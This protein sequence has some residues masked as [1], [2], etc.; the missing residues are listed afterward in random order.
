MR[1][2]FCLE[3]LKLELA[4][5]RNSGLSVGFTCGAFD[6][7]HVGHLDYLEKARALCDRLIVAVNSDASIRSYKNPLRP[8]IAEEQRARLMA[9][10]SC[11]DAVIIMRETRPASLIEILKPDVYVKG[12]DYRAA[13]LR[14][15]PVVEAYGGRCVVVPIVEEVSTTKI[16]ERVQHLHL[17]AV[18]ESRDLPV[19]CRIVFLDRDG[20]L[21]RNIHFLN[22]PRRVSL[23]PEVGHGLK[24]LQ[25]EGFVL[26]VITNQQGL[27]L[28]YF[29]YDTFVSINSEMLRQLDAF[30]V[31]IARFYFCP[32]SA[33]AQCECRKPKSGLLR[34]AIADF[35]SRPENCVMIGDSRSDIAAAEGAGCQ[36]FLVSD[37]A[38]EARGGS[39]SSFETA[40]EQVLAR[41]TASRL[42]KTE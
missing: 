30:S 39:V 35:Q 7:L 18:P 9:A 5:W 22:D 19:N 3:T 26:V 27:G 21:I 15:A 4:S 1:K 10:L 42:T 29:D 16:I 36:A 33:L 38:A 6:L 24:R 14:S 13:E 41:S 34:R 23:L 25:D 12:G 32:H 31:R 2:V 8:V 28:G 17:H 20:T 37:S 40:V 11:V